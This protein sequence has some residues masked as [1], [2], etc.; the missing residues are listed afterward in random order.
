MTLD[1]II[2]TLLRLRVIHARLLRAEL[3]EIPTE[4][5]MMSESVKL[6]I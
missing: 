6:A 1:Q 5:A 2:S 4:Y 3:T